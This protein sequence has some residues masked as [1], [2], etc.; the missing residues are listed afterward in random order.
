MSV[1]Y[2]SNDLFRVYSL[3]QN[4]KKADIYTLDGRGDIILKV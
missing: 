3:V 2:V 1:S 4:V